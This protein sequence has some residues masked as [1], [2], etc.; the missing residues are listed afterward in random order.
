MIEKEK[1]VNGET[2]QKLATLIKENF[3][4]K[5]DYDEKIADFESRIKA[6]ETGGATQE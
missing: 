1:N 4:L 3:V 2:L 6:L 5:S